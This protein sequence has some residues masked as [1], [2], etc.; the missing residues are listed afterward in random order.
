[1]RR[2]A[3]IVAWMLAACAGSADAGD[4]PPRSTTQLPSLCVP[5]PDEAMTYSVL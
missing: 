4:V 1:M 3:V 2:L 5:S